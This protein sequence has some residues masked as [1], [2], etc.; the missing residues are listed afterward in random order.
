MM[1]FRLLRESLR[2]AVQALILNKLRTFLSLLGITIG[3]FSIISVLTAFDALE[4]QI[5]KSISGLGSDVIYIQKFPF[6]QVGEN[7]PWWRYLQRPQPRQQELSQLLRSSST[8][9]YGAFTF[10]VNRTVEY[11]SN[12]LDQVDI[13]SVSQDFVNLRNFNLQEGRFFTPIESNGGQA[14]AVLGHN[15]AQNLFDQEEPVGKYIKIAGYRCRVI[16]VVEQR[17]DNTF[18]DP[19]D[20]QVIVP[21]SFAQRFARSRWI[22]TTILLSARKGVSVEQMKDEVTGLM[23]SIRHLRPGEDNNFSINQVDILEQNLNKVFGVIGIVGW[24]VGGFSLLVGGFGIANIMFVSV[25]ER[26]SQI[27]IQKAIGAKNK[28]IMQQFLFESVFLSLIGGILGLLIVF[29]LGLLV[30]FAF[31]FQVILGLKNI[32]IGIGVS[33]VIG[34]VA[35][36]IPAY[37]ASRLDPVDA[38][39]SGM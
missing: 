27:G 17:G 34:V 1:L 3:I 10:D 28:F 8:V 21:A 39:R 26:T 11:Q 13:L 22:N 7:Y 33:C 15:I 18:S 12:N 24:V 35:G 14:V 9:E 2:F 19:N 32:L 29:L 16:G 6:G 31:D 20:N 23:R 4:A 25:K 30:T 38:M 37:T 36:Y 5:R